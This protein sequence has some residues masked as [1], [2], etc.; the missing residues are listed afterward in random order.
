[1][2]YDNLNQ[3]AGDIQALA[4]GFGHMRAMIA[5]LLGDEMALEDRVSRQGWWIEALEAQ[6]NDMRR[7]EFFPAPRPP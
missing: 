2:E 1:M 5:R 4:D 7:S 3:V 6:V